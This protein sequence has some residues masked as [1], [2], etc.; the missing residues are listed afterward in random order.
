MT[1]TPKS[2]PERMLAVMQDV[3]AAGKDGWNEKQRYAFTSAAGLQMK[4][5][6]AFIKHGLYICDVSYGVVSEGTFKTNSGSEWA[7]AVVSCSLSVTDS[8]GRTAHSTGLGCGADPADKHVMKAQTAALKYALSALF[9]SALGD[10]PEADMATDEATA[11]DEGPELSPEYM[12]LW[13]EMRGYDFSPGGIDIW[14]SEVGHRIHGLDKEEQKMFWE[15][16]KDACGC[17]AEAK[18]AGRTAIVT[19]A[20]LQTLWRKHVMPAHYNKHNEEKKT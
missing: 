18:Q 4:V 7:R 14:L 13:R 17:G 8:D 20:A 10:D 16:V 3:G 11:E 12:D 1:N 9:L 19:V 6:K 15:T 2:F 5:Q